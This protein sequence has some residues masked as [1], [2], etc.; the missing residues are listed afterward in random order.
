MDAALARLVRLR[1]ADRCEYCQLP[2][3][4]SPLTHEVDHIIAQKHPGADN[5]THYLPGVLCVQ[6]S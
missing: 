1:A 2:Q 6:Q 3:A 4:H 5:G